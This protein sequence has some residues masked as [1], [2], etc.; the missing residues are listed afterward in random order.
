MI[1]IMRTIEKGGR[2]MHKN[3]SVLYR[4]CLLLMMVSKNAEGCRSTFL[5]IEV[6]AFSDNLLG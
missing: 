2:V 6:K 3:L 5:D 1:N 4:G